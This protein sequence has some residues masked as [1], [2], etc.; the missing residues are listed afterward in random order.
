MLYQGTSVSCIQS[1]VFG[2]TTANELALALSSA[3]CGKIISIKLLPSM[4]TLYHVYVANLPFMQCEE[5][6]SYFEGA[7]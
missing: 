6:S 5:Q 7:C 1:T 2:L 4:A 3:R